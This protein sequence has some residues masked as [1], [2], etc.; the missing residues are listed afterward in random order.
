[1]TAIRRWWRN[2]GSGGYPEATKL[3]ITA[4]SGG[5]NA[6]RRRLWKVA[7]QRLTDETGLAIRPHS[8]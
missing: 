6:S 3:L 4:E 5:S 8:R 1:M 7:L 2:M